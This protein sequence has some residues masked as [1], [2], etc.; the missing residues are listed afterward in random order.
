MTDL[1]APVLMQPR[2]MLILNRPI[3]LAERGKIKIGMKGAVSTS[4]KGN[5][6]Q[7]PQKLD[8]FIVTT[9]EQG[10]DG[11]F[12]RD[13][14][15][16]KI[17]GDKPTEIPVKLLWNDPMLSWQSRYAA[18]KGKTLWCSGNGQDA[19][20][21]GVACS[22]PCERIAQD[23]KGDDKCKINGIL[24][25]M[26]EGAPGV[27]GVWKFRTTSFNSVDGLTASIM[28]LHS[29]T[30]GQ[31]AGVPLWLTVSPKKATDPSGK[32]Q[33][34]YVVNL[35]YRGSEAELREHAHQIALGNATARLNIEGVEAQARRMLEAPQPVDAILPGDDS[36]DVRLEFYPHTEQSESPPASTQGIPAGTHPPV[37]AAPAP[38]PPPPSQTG[39]RAPGG[40]GESQ[41]AANPACPKC[42]T[43]A[44]VIT[45]KY[46]KNLPEGCSGWI[47]Y[48]GPQGKPGKWT[49]CGMKWTIGG[50]SAASGELTWCE[51]AIA[52]LELIDITAENGREELDQLYNGKPFG[53]IY[54]RCNEE[55]QKRIVAKHDALL[56]MCA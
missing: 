28:F 44:S 48:G 40:A 56:E 49:G 1:R 36:E 27:G 23:Y 54:Q 8:H 34:I 38:T 5:T 7:P 12:I 33:T 6:F 51:K 30:S 45:D 26:I 3:R 21:E 41:G 10:L 47:H 18:Y 50:P 37:S 32:Q 16:H 2:S 29:A 25:V 35:E 42:K 17:I 24:S 52:M 46:A 13:E 14:E 11:N 53:V 39:Q 31:L 9:M 55:E 20:R 22:C 15:I 4:A 43:S 19:I